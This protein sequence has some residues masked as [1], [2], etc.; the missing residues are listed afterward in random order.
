MVDKGRPDK[1]RI[2]DAEDLTMKYSASKQDDEL[3]F[4]LG[5]SLG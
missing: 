3:S 2:E 4:P 5:I 1:P